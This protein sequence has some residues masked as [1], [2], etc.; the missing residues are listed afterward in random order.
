MSAVS[1]NTYSEG[2]NHRP[3]SRTIIITCR[4]SVNEYRM[5][6]AIWCEITLI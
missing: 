4:V 6:P 5:T 2:E 1:V 3:K